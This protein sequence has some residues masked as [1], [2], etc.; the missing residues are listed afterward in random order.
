MHLAR[1]SALTRVGGV[2][3]LVATF[4]ARPDIFR[5]VPDAIREADMRLRRGIRH[6]AEFA[7]ARLE[8]ALQLERWQHFSAPIRMG[9]GPG[10]QND[11]DLRAD[12]RGFGPG[13]LAE[14]VPGV[15]SE[16]RF[17]LVKVEVEVALCP[18]LARG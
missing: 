4:R 3:E 13:E 5:Q 12:A 15:R 14:P 17:N 7:R 18:S 6:P 16:Q 11:P 9:V 8:S 2:G 1:I 10:R